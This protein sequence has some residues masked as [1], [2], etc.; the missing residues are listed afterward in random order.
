MLAIHRMIALVCLLPLS[1]PVA[2]WFS[3]QVP[4]QENE[5]FCIKTNNNNVKRKK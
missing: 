3:V 5:T 4:S 1:L 2:C